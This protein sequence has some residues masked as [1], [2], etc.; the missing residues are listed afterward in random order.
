MLGSLSTKQHRKCESFFLVS[1][2]TVQGQNIL[3]FCT[4]EHHHEFGPFGLLGLLKAQCVGLLAFLYCR[5]LLHSG[6]KTSS[7]VL[8]MILVG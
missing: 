3:C 5:L 6:R 2:P 7:S 8:T 4:A 1:L